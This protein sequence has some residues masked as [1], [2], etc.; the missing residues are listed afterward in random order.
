M[1]DEKKKKKEEAARKKQEQEVI[2]TITETPDTLYNLDTLHV[3]SLMSIDRHFK[4]IERSVFLL[5]LHWIICIINICIFYVIDGK[6]G[7]NEG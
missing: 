3:K 2:R 6:V 7:K 4:Y 1:E 5:V